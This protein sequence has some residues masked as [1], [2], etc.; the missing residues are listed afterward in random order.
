[1]LSSTIRILNYFA[2]I[3]KLFDITENLKEYLNY[4]RRHIKY[5]LHT[6]SL[7]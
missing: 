7:Q 4:Y 2:N 3:P 6:N 1:M 5:N